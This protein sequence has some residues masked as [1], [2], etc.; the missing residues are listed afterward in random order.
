LFSFFVVC[1]VIS[2]I[3][4]HSYP[5]ILLFKQNILEPDPDAFVNNAG[6]QLAWVV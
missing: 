3:T 5:K 6:H 2:K 4:K 1:I